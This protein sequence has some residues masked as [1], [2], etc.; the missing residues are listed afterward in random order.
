MVAN[1]ATSLIFQIF[2][3]FCLIIFSLFF[4]QA[5]RSKT[6][7]GISWWRQWRPIWQHVHYFKFSR[8]F[9]QL[10]MNQ[11]VAPMVANLATSLIFQIF[12]IFFLIIFLLFFQQAK[13]SKT[14]TGISWWR[15]WRPIW[16][17]VQY[18]RLSNVF[19]HRSFSFWIFCNKFQLG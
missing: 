15:Q 11:L 7:T 6:G 13:R 3:I 12:T 9:Y 17:H 4:Q 1:L 19:R 10:F 8:I 18:R 14:R 16:Q 5:K 2:T